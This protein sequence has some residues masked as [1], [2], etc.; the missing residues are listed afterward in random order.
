MTA[1]NL[2]PRLPV[3]LLTAL[4]AFV[5]TGCVRIEMTFTVDEDG[6]GAVDMVVAVDE[7]L[8][9]ASGESADDMLGDVDDLPPGAVVSEYREDGFVGQRM[10]VPVADME[11]AAESLGSTD[12]MTDAVDFEFVREGNNWRF[13]MDVPP[14]GQELAGENGDISAGLAAS[15][16]NIP[17]FRVRVSLPGEITEHNADQ[18]EDGVLVWDLDLMSGEP[19]TLS[20]RSE[21]AGVSPAIVAVAIGAG[22]AVVVLAAVAVRSAVRGRRGA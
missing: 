4:C 19:R 21:L 12:N 11:R 20:A 15:V 22:V 7:A 18:V 2:V 14:L 16:V 1:R 8:L 17:E 6:S 10:S 9:A 5:L 13:T 3:A